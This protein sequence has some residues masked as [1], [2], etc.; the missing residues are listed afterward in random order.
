MEA[1]LKETITLPLFGQLLGNLAGTRPYSLSDAGQ[2]DKH[3]LAF[4]G[5][6]RCRPKLFVLGTDA[7]TLSQAGLKP[8]QWRPR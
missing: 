3:D 4:V 2:A 8:Y 1:K 7:D 5:V 6:N